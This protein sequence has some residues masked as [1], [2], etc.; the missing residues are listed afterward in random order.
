MNV[1]LNFIERKIETEKKEGKQIWLQ[2]GLSANP[3]HLGH[4]SYLNEMVK[5]LQPDRVTVVP[6]KV[7]PWK[8]S[9]PQLT[10]QQKEEVAK[11]ALS[12]H[13][14]WRVDTQELY[15]QEE[16]SYTWKA[17]YHISKEAKEKNASLYLMMTDETAES[18]YKW[19]GADFIVGKATIVYGERPGTTFDKTLF[20]NTLHK[21][22]ELV[23]ARG[24]LA[25]TI[26]IQVE[27]GH[28]TM[29]ARTLKKDD[30]PG[31]PISD[32]VIKAM[33]E[34]Y[35]PVK[36]TIEVSSSL[37]RENAA[38]GLSIVGLVGQKVADLV[39]QYRLFEK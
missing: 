35:V 13:P 2:F 7:N 20:L 14:D 8:T 17:I 31:V 9:I 37:I 27:S 4:V 26:D 34:G 11:A 6:T 21:I 39:K 10:P 12:D 5:A 29:V 1:S 3:M 33:E 23:I 15:S 18:F 38:K 25:D 36:G 16:C 32:A 24:I 28:G 22:N 19:E 30:I